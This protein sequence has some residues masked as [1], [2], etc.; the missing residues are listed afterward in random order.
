[1]DAPV[2]FAGEQ[3]SVRK[4]VALAKR[5]PGHWKIPSHG[6]ARALA[7]ASGSQAWCQ[8]LF[9]DDALMP[10]VRGVLEYA[11]HDVS[12]GL[13]SQVL[14]WSNHGR[15]VSVGGF[16]DYVSRL[17]H[18]DGPLL[19]IHQQDMMDTSAADAWGGG[20]STLGL[21]SPRSVLSAT[22]GNGKEQD[23]HQQVVD[24]LE[25]HR[26]VCWHGSSVEDVLELA[27]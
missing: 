4:R 11:A 12:A 20:V 25:D 27:G 19:V 24:W 8:H 2:Y 22:I 3:T 17:G 1:M 15:L 21:T 16:V 23:T 5:L 9:G 10:R 13:V 26:S 7:V 18:G 14:E 6:A